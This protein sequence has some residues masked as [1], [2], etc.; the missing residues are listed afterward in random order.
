M[1]KLIAICLM[2]MVSGCFKASWDD[3]KLLVESLAVDKHLEGLKIS[4]DAEGGFVVEIKKSS[5]EGQD[6]AI[7]IAEIVK[8]ALEG[9]IKFYTLG[10]AAGAAGAV[11]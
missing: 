10:Q 6:S 3:E 4:Q 11:P 1:K 9:A 2:I 8:T 5:I 7:A